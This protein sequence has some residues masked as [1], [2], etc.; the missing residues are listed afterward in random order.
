[1]LYCF[2]FFELLIDKRI[3]CIIRFNKNKP[4]E[5]QAIVKDKQNQQNSVRCSHFIYLGTTLLCF[6]YSQW[7]FIY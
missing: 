1:M 6:L 3:T 5:L 7:M 4:D 2:I